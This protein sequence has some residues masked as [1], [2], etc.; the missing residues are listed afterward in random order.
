MPLLGRAAMLLGFDVGQLR[1]RARLPAATANA[2]YR[3]AYAL[4]EREALQPE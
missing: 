4:T 2:L 3:Q 1:P